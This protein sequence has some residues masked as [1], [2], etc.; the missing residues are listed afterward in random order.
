MATEQLPRLL[1][2]EGNRLNL[3]MVGKEHCKGIR[4]RISYGGIGASDPFGA[5]KH[6]PESA[7]V[8]LQKLHALVI[9]RRHRFTEKRRNQRPEMIPG[10][11]IILLEPQRLLSRQS[12]ED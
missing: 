2:V 9:R 10:M 6:V 11:A 12:A 8:P 1:S 4:Y 3:R 5:F 7:S